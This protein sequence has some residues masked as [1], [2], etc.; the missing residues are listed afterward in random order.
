ME[1]CRQHGIPIVTYP[2]EELELEL[3]LLEVPTVYNGSMTRVD[4]DKLLALPAE[5]R[6]HLAEALWDSLEGEQEVVPIS[7]AQRELLDRRLEAYRAEPDNLLTW[8]EVR[9]RLA[10]RA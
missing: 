2:P 5:D 8:S 6:L 4:M 1:A 9:A 7:T 10:R 3:K